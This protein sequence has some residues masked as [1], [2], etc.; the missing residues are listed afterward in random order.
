MNDRIVELETKVSFQEQ[1]IN[2]LSDALA[3]QQRQIEIL[4]KGLRELHAQFTA[5]LPSLVASEAEETP[6]PHY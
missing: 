6:P 1:A 3:A 5:A 4:E 2:E